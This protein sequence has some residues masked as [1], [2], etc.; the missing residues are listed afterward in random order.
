MDKQLQVLDELIS[1]VEAAGIPIWFYGGYALDAL[2]N[3]NIR[4]HGDID[5]FVCRKDHSRLKSVLAS[6]GFVI[7]EEYL[8]GTFFEKMGQSV[9]C[10]TYERLADGRYVTNTG[11]TGVY[12]WP[13]NSFPDKPNA[14]LLGKQVRVVSYEALYVF[15]AGYQTYDP[16]Q[17]LREKD[18]A[19]LRIICQRIPTKVRKEL[20]SLF[21]PLPGT[22]SRCPSD[23]L[24][25]R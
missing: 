5:F 22:R 3:R 12:P 15:K 25:Q 7:S 21:D 23:G 13:E 9:E 10:L 20:V 19:D 11:E 1:L 14:V 4:S 17:T 6:S 18:A 2:E 24:S 16:T 8:I